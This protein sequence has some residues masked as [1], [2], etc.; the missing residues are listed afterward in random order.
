ML[1]IGRSRSRAFIRRQKS[2]FTPYLL[3]FLPILIQDQ[4]DRIA[5][6]ISLPR[7][8]VCKIHKRGE[9]T[10]LSSRISRRVFAR[11]RWSVAQPV[12][13]II[14]RLGA[15]R[16]ARRRGRRR[17]NSCHATACGNGKRYFSCFRDTLTKK[18]GSFQYV[19]IIAGGD[20]SLPGKGACLESNCSDTRISPTH[21]HPVVTHPSRMYTRR[22]LSGLHTRSNE[23]SI[24]RFL[25]DFK[26]RFV[27][28]KFRSYGL[29]KI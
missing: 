8:G 6:R 2:N 12:G 26:F 27:T 22:I 5:S 11:D 29:G 25:T 7:S 1:L 24:D 28:C 9:E 14:G 23:L 10:F 21:H 15:R 3:L 4:G 19:H 16:V 13:N 18:H 17:F 20:F